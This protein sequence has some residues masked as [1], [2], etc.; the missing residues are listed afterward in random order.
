MVNCQVI[1]SFLSSCQSVHDVSKFLKTQVTILHLQ[2]GGFFIWTYTYQLIR[3]SSI[4]FNALKASEE[5]IKSPNK[6]LEANERTKLLKGRVQESA[7]EHTE[8]HAVSLL[9]YT[10]QKH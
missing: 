7:K 4:R 1:L 9:H 6:D 2:L 3:S 10:C 8:S 5:A